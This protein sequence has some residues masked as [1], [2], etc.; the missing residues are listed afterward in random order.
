M[1]KNIMQT[2]AKIPLGI[3]TIIGFHL[4]N[5][6]LWTIGQGGAVISYDTVAEW[7]LQDLRNIIDPA[8]VEVNK[9][10]GLADMIILIPLFIVS[11]FGLWRKKF[12]GIIFS[13][14]ALGITL[15]WPTVFFCSQYFY[16]EGGIKHAHTPI[17]TIILLSVILIFAL[18]S[19]WY[20]IKNYKKLN[21]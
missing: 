21:Y 14:L 16:G 5:I 8:I 11:V 1:G 6:I 13:W 9:A 15:Y 2:K 3:K 12:Y 10:I 19:C 4:L 18:W 7:G 20:L 17:S